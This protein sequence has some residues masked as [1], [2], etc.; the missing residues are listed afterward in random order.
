MI[1][2]KDILHTYFYVFL[3]VYI[4]KLF[5]SFPLAYFSIIKAYD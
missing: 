2:S 4:V 1:I 3:Y 5:F